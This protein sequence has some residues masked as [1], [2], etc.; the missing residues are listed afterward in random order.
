MWTHNAL[1]G[2]MDD[3]KSMSVLGSNNKF[4]LLDTNTGG[5]GLRGSSIEKDKINSYKSIDGKTIWY[6]L[7]FFKQILFVFNF[8]IVLLR[9][10]SYY[11]FM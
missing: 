8:E 1:G 7:K 9:L 3:K 10:Y 11:I 2:K 6:N 4:A 5:A